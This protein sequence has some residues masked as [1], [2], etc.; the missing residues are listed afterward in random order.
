MKKQKSTKRA[1]LMSALSLLLCL[2]MLVGTTFAWFTDSVT[3]GN[4]RIQS[5]NLDIELEYWDGK[6]WVDV[7]GKSD[8]LTN[9][10]WEPGVTEV[11][12]LRVANA[13]S[14]ALKY[15]LGIN[16][17]SETAGVNQAGD[18]FKLSDYIYFD[19]IE[20]DTLK[21]F[22]T[23]EDAVA[24]VTDAKKIS[25]GYTKAE[26]LNAGKEFYLALVVYMPTSVGNEANHNGEDVPSIDLG[27]NIVATQY[28]KENDSYGP[29]YDEDAWADGFQVFTAQDL[30]AA[31][32]NGETNI[33][34]MDDIELTKTLEIP[35]PAASTYAMRATQ[36]PIVLDL[37]G[38][39]ITSD[40]VSGGV[41]LVQGA[42][43]IKNGVISTTNGVCG[44]RVTGRSASLTLTNMTVAVTG[45]GTNA[46]WNH[47]AVG[48]ANG[49]KLVINSGS[50]SAEKGYG[51]VVMTSGADV[52]INDGTF[53][54]Q[55]TTNSAAVRFD[56]GWDNSKVYTNAVIN[57]GMFNAP[58]GGLAFVA[59]NAYGKA[60]AINGGIFNGELETAYQEDGVV[61]NGG[62]FNKT[63]F[64]GGGHQDKYVIKGGTF[65][66]NVSKK[67]AEGYKAVP[68]DGKYIVASE[69]AVA[70]TDKLIEA[71]NAGQTKIE[72]IPGV[73]A[74]RF[75]NNTSF[76]LN[77]KTIKGLGEVE[78]AISSSE[79][80]YGRIQ[81][82]DVTFENIH[83]TS[84]VGA[85]GKATYNNC[86]FDSWTICASS[87]KEETYFNNCTINGC[88]N[89]STDFSSGDVYVKDS[90]I[91]KAEYSGSMTMN[92]ENC[93]ID[94]M[95]IWNANT[96]LTNCEVTTLD[97]SNVTNA[98]VKIDGVVQAATQ[99]ALNNAFS[100]SNV[101]VTLAAGEYKMPSSNATGEVTISG[102]KDTVLDVT[103]GAYMDSADGVTIEGVTIKT[104]TGMVNGNGSDYA[105]LYT[106]NVTYKN[107]TF[108]GPM[109]VGRDGAKFINCTFTELGNDYIWNY[110]NDVTFEGC[111]FNTDG[112]AILLYS[113]GG[114]EVA[115]VTVKNCVFNS[116]HG[117]KAGAIANQNCAAI[118][119]H[120]YGNGVNLV[121]EGNT[122]D[123]NFSGE[124]RIKTYE[125]GKTQVFV[126]GAEYT[127]IA[128]DG[129]L[130]TID[131]DRNVTVNG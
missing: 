68:S 77:G 3:S 7:A 116:T 100:G 63:I 127:Q 28:T 50:Y 46:E 123:S 114:N 129:K 29:D 18:E 131:A 72:L 86:T 76:N 21:T 96:N 99:D 48:A 78:L 8:I 32:N 115:K 34:L 124:W 110:G 90:E 9:T 24:A 104:S 59:N 35:A 109:R 95:I 67:V 112:K 57:G 4:N 120:N 54:T 55:G 42:A 40:L 49:A 71:I 33:V 13:G 121:T 87:N 20:T 65:A 118:E 97:Q 130:M 128:V 98:V 91:A 16:I 66:E 69:N 37:N 2:S 80:W 92:F 15:Q 5:G 85:T 101:N 11:A 51:L 81:A 88:L 31:I 79:A 23:R 102:T 43:E 73:Y 1:L 61:I 103:L 111:T 14:L 58:E 62:T 83:F 45:T 94:E 47:T 84:A 74:L 38:K 113:D 27:I 64:Q 75:T 106:P 117:A 126:N 26:S 52:T 108:V 19:V 89:T 6:A 30:Q 70:N 125:T 122:Y 17:V 41:I 53:T 25:A 82:S 119:I 56:S 22:A 44:L 12:Y 93:E 60:I 36:N 39:K 107:C 10:L 105:A